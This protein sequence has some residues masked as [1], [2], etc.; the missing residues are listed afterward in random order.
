MSLLSDFK[1]IEKKVEHMMADVETLHDT[2]WT[3]K[4]KASKEVKR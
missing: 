2:L 3:I 4:R 1:K